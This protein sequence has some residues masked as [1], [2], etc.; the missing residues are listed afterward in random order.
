MKTI[1]LDTR[2]SSDLFISYLVDTSEK[3]G[4]ETKL[5]T[6]EFGD[7]N[8][9]NIYIERKTASDFCSSV[10]SDRLWE[11]AYKMQENKDYT[12]IIII[13]GGWDKLRKDDFDKIPQLEGAIIQLL[14]WGIP[15]L[16]VEDDKELVDQTLKI[17]KHS[18]PIEV[19]IKHVEKN[20]KISMFLALP[21]IG[22]K[23]G[24]V[25]MD[26]YDNMYKLC[27][28]SKKELQILLGSKRGSMVYDA[29]RR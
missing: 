18:K 27:E 13:S 10:C 24:K 1:Y 17:F 6:L 9:Q 20:K 12:S 4:Y 16:R 11:Q 25:L 14:A 28:A 26:E 23:N 2:E 15:V 21:S 5:S 22:R 3:N 7:I 8:F 29:L 19:P